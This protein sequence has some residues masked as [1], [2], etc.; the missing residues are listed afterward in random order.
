MET[1]KF[2]KS[3]LKYL[4]TN[5]LMALGTSFKDRPWSA[6]V[7][8][9]FDNDFN[10]LFFSR[11]DTR[12]CQNIKKNKYVSI[13]IN[14]DWGKPGLV[15]GLQ[16]TGIASKVPAKQ[17]KKYFLIYSERFPWAEEFPDHSL[18]IIKPAEIH[19]IDQ[20]FFGHFYRVKIL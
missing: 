6:T 3:A 17:Q 19:Y 12:H 15:K 14:Q 4:K 10:I 8:F 20:E 9:A 16:M 5:R 1:T 13:A 11:E 2:I 7:F 18:Y